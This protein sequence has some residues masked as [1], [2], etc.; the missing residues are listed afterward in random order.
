MDNE[1]AVIRDLVALIDELTGIIEEVAPQRLT[2]DL[3]ERGAALMERAGAIT[4]SAD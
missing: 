1:K 4:E 2:Q 3:G